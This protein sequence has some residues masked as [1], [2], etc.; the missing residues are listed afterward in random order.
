MSFHRV[1]LENWPRRPYFEHDFHTLPCTYSMT[2]DVD[3]TV[4]LPWLRE[5]SMRFYP[6]V[7]F[8]LPVRSTPIR[9]FAWMWMPKVRWGIT[10]VWTP[11]I[12]FSTRKARRFPASGP[13]IRRILRR[14]AGRGR[15]IWPG[16]ARFRVPWPCSGARAGDL[17]RLGGAMDQFYR[18][19]FEFAE[20]IR[21]SAADLY[22]GQVPDGTWEDTAAVGGAGPSRGGGRIPCGA[23]FSRLQS[24]ADSCGQT[25]QPGEERT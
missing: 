13:P 3:V 14:S 7:I 15:R 2:A 8:G 22:A 16:S 19:Q 5:K 6:A 17:Q 12:R 18:V 10:T 24:W 21:L 4:L 25:D 23:A 20:G 1:D 11:A 9:R